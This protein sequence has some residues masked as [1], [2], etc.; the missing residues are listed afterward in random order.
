M[1][2]TDFASYVSPGTGKIINSRL[3]QQDDLKRSGAILAEPG[4]DKDIARN[5]AAKADREFAPVA[6][7]VDKTISQLVNSG[8][9][10]G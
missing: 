5:K 3:A 9:I 6:A 1:V 4:L 10:Q 8:Q 7:A 2:I